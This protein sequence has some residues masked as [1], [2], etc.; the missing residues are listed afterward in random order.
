MKKNVLINLICSVIA[1][2]VVI[3]GVILGMILTGNM[4]VAKKK[5][6]I[7]SSSVAAVYNGETLSDSKWYL[8]EGELKEGHTLSVSVTGAQKNVGVSE[9]HLHAKVLDAQGL[10]VSSDYNIEYRPGVLNVKARDICIVAESAG[11]IYDGEPLTCD[12]YYLESAIALLPTD[13]LSV[14]V[15]GSITEKGE[16]ANRV[17]AAQITNE[18]GADVSRNYHITTKDGV[19]L[20]YDEKTLVFQ[21]DSATKEFDGRT[22]KN[23][24][25]QIKNGELRTDHWLSV[26]FTGSQLMVGSSENTFTV[27]IYDEQGNDVT[28]SYD[29]IYRPGTLVVTRAKVTITSENGYKAYD[30]LPLTNS[31]FEVS[32]S[33]YEK[34]GFRFEPVIT[35]SQTEIGVSENTIESCKVYSSLNIDVTEYFDITPVNGT[36]TVVPEALAANKLVIKTDD[37]TKDFDGTPLTNKNWELVEGSLK[38]GHYL[39]INVNGSRTEIGDEDNTLSVVVRDSSGKDVTNEYIDVV[40]KPGTLTVEMIDITVQAGS[41][42]KKYDG[43][44]LECDE[45]I[46]A[47]FDL[48]EK[49]IFECVTYGSRTNPGEGVNTVLSCRI[50]EKNKKGE[51][52]DEI[53]QNFNITKLTGKLVVLP[54]DEEPLVEL[55]YTSY[56][57]SKVYDGTPL[58]GSNYMR[59]GS[60]L[61]GHRE[62]VIFQN[63]ITKVGTVVNSFTVKIYDADGNDVSDKYLIRSEFGSLTVTPK[64]ITVTASSDTKI[65][66]GL[67]LTNSGYELRNTDRNDNGPVLAAGDTIK[68][69]VVGS[70]TDPGRIDNVISTIG[71]TNADNEDVTFC[72]DITRVRGELKVVEDTGSGGGN[73][74]GG[75]TGGGGGGGNSNSK[76]TGEV[77]FKVTST[78]TGRIY[79]KMKSMGDYDLY[80]KQWTEALPYSELIYTS[81]E[82]GYVSSYYMPYLALK[83]VGY[84]ESSVTIESLKGFYVLPYYTHIQS[85]VNQISDVSVMGNASQPYT[86]KYYNW[87]NYEGI[88][89][90][91]RYLEYEQ[92]Y[93]NYVYNNYLYV[94]GETYD[95]MQGVIAENGFA[96]PADGTVNGNIIYK[97]ASYIQNAATYNLDYD[98]AVDEAA[99]P[100]IAFLTT[101]PEG[102]CRHYAQAATLLYRSLGIPA[103]YTE[104]F[105]ADVKAGTTVDVTDGEGHA[106][107]EVYVSG[108]GWLKVEVTGS[109]D[110]INGS[111]NGGGGGGGG[112]GSAQKIKLT[113]TPQL[114]ENLYDGMPHAAKQSVK[115]EGANLASYG[116]TYDVIVDGERTEPGKTKSQVADMIIYD[117]DGNVIYQK[118]TNIGKDLFDIT[119]NTGTLH[120]Y[121]TEISFKSSS[122][123]KIYDGTPLE[124]SVSSVVH[125]SGAPINGETI[126]IAVT[127]SITNKGVVAN[128]FTVKII[129]SSGANVTDQYKINYTYGSLSI[130]AR[131]ITLTAE[132]VKRPYDGT[133]LEAPNITD[134]HESQLAEGD[135]VE[136]YTVTG[137]QTLPGWAV[138][139]LDP[140]TVVIC[141][142]NGDNVTSNYIVITENGRLTVTG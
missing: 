89:L 119:Y 101:H 128:T 48:E 69:T 131:E 84:Q 24:N 116:Y 105:V 43:T 31:S 18:S 28:G 61:A 112:G 8:T 124:M 5:L 83:S 1:T 79:L 123:S 10:D 49:Y 26:E 63:E 57:E 132:S 125:T 55:T 11:K 19:L 135:Y 91:S 99:N 100:T 6:V 136:S 115:L 15:E 85:G 77:Y 30:G 126:E 141:N 110:S 68:V 118:S 139:V 122:D 56:N 102:V 133:T 97:V 29:I 37:A 66:D 109:D 80:N 106:W 140:A 62:E 127:G 134:D 82:I 121:L 23:D 86:V 94:D 2:M 88:Q 70:I 4:D 78:D 40:K 17:T 107:V 51:K 114:T 50:Y 12:S 32:P 52:G 44:P 104:G 113:V 87:N 130:E 41:A 117:A 7:S 22:L 95:F 96:L 64:K 76:P 74:G 98:T 103:R 39:D 59:D 35:G 120:V 73:G 47:P 129:D 90:S 71:I 3:V 36:L 9:N 81:Q 138:N 58:T 16:A 13:T 142:Q 14:T 60:L 42:Q 25:W 46:V 108:I 21:S 111:L 93:R 38:E 53:T 67:P 72:Y 92:L 137:S 45:Y 54:G 75:G 27:T 34:K 65:Y 20:V 33:D